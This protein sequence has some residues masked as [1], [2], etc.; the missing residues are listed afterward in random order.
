M[1]SEQQGQETAQVEPQEQQPPQQQQRPQQARDQFLNMLHNHINHFTYCRKRPC[2]KC[3]RVSS[4]FTNFWH[5]SYRLFY[6]S[7]ND[8]TI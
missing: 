2:V 3:N 1:V 8:H 5:I 4:K 6:I 7:I